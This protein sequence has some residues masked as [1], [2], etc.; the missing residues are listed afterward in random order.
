M[1]D[2]L[3]R[4]VFNLRKGLLRPLRSRFRPLRSGFR[5]LRSRSD[6]QSLRDGRL[7]GSGTVCNTLSSVLEPSSW[8]GA[9]RKF[10]LALCATTL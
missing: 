2:F 1:H 7:K 9:L 5:P 8:E 6:L 4:S 3:R 10:Y